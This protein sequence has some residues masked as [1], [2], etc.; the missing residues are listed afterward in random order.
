MP[1]DPLIE[2]PA[3]VPVEAPGIYTECPACGVLVV[4]TATHT[5]W[6]AAHGEGE[7]L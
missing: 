7:V 3:E 2:P 1:E 6:H 5:A 4:D